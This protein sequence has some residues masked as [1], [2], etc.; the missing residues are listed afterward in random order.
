M[1]PDPAFV[2]ATLVVAPTGGGPGGERGANRR[3]EDAAVVLA[4]SL[5]SRDRHAW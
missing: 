2:G 1:A 5:A 3:G 4:G